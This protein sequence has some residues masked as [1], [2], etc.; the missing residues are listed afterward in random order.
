MQGGKKYREEVHSETCG[1][2]TVTIRSL[3]PDYLEEERDK[4]KKEIAKTL[5]EVFSKY[6]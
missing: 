3:T 1:G 6:R 4:V 5:Y 2:K